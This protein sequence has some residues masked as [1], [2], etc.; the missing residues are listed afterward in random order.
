MNAILTIR[1]L[2]GIFDLIQR[3]DFLPAHSYHLRGRKGRVLGITGDNLCYPLKNSGNATQLKKWLVEVEDKRFY[4]HGAVDWKGVLRAIVKNTKA[5]KITQGGSTI[6][7]QLA[8][9]LFLDA[10]RT[11]IRKVAE[12]IIAFKLEKH[13]T[14]EEILNAYCDFVYMG[15]GSRG[16][17][18]AS[19]VL[20]RRSFDSLAPSKIPPLVGLLGAPEKFH[21]G[22]DEKKFWNRA[23]QKA[24]S[25]GMDVNKVPLNPIRVSRSFSRRIENVVKSELERL[26]LA[27]QNIKAVELT[28]DEILQG[29]IDKELKEIS[30]FQNVRQIAAVVICNSTGDVLAE[31]AW[32]KGAPSE[33]S[34]SFFG[35]IQPGSTFKTFAFLTAIE[36]GLS[37]DAVFESAPYQ[38]PASLGR[39]WNVRNYGEIYREKLTLEDAL[40][41]SDNTVFARLSEFLSTDDLASTYERFSL[42]GKRSF[43]RAAILGGVRDGVSL[44]RIA[45]AYASIARNGIKIEPRLIRFVEYQNG[46]TVYVGSSNERVVADYEATQILKLILARSGVRSVSL[47]IPGKTGTTSKGSLFAGYTEDVSI[48]LWLDFDHEQ[49]EHDPKALTAMRVMKKIGHRLLAWSDQRALAII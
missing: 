16:F 42:V 31:S 15:R 32:G 4:Q 45:N 20:Y 5:G 40:V 3:G 49:P 24:R 19:R 37:P 44:L 26:G 6:T 13:L 39:P 25:L 17:E 36:S 14:K 7:Q 11:W 27:Q 21:P 33:F 29:K 22:S 2:P 34:P 8:R 41:M 35:R 9:T 12:T 46:A 38:S 1:R 47:N 43:T 30:R 28:I 10:S 18:A 23:G 48:G